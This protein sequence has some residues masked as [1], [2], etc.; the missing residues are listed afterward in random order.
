[1]N[2]KVRLVKEADSKNILEIYAPFITDTAV[3]FEY[4]VPS[5]EE[6]TTRIKSIAEEYPYLVCEE[7]NEITGYAYAHRYLERA[8]YQWDVEVTIYLAPAAQKKGIGGLLYAK[9]EKVLFAQGIKN[10]YACITANNEQS[11]KFHEKCGYNLVG[12]F[13]KAGYKNDAW[14]DVVWMEKS[15]AGFDEKPKKP[16]SISQFDKD[17]IEKILNQ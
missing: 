5:E 8:A 9:L 13:K 12:T 3:S 15:I 2:Y 4:T 11:I 10:L 17:S 6:F 16:V 7:D 1:M 14:Q